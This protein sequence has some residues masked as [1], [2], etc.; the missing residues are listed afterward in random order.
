MVCGG[1]LVTWMETLLDT[2]WKQDALNGSRRWN[3]IAEGFTRSSRTSST[4]IIEGGLEKRRL[5]YVALLN[6]RKLEALGIA[7]RYVIWINILEKLD[8]GD[9]QALHLLKT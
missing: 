9:R 5:W 1:E 8:D 7:A 4:R 2:R 3:G 6:L